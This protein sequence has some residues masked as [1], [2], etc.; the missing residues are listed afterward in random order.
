MNFQDENKKLKKI[1]RVYIVILILLGLLSFFVIGP[2][3]YNIW[4]VNTYP[5]MAGKTGSNCYFRKSEGHGNIKYHV[6]FK[7]EEA[8]ELYIN[9]NLKTRFEILEQYKILKQTRTN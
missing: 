9:A 6:Y 4:H 7:T 5:W 8:C 1:K 2:T 3:I